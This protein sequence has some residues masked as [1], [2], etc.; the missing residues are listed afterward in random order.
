MRFENYLPRFQCQRED[1]T[2]LSPCFATRLAVCRTAHNAYVSGTIAGKKQREQ[3]AMQGILKGSHSQ[4]FQPSIILA[5][6]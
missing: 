2:A 1:N 4:T 6:Y 5:A 3:V